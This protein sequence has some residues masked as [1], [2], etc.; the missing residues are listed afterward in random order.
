MSG[1]FGVTG[2][3]GG[4]GRRTMLSGNSGVAV[5]GRGAGVA[6]SSGVSRVAG[7]TGIAGSS[8]IPDFW[9]SGLTGRRRISGL[10]N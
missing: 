4:P 7:V 2:V 6:G 1:S 9:I 10:I 8:G 3:P 5:G